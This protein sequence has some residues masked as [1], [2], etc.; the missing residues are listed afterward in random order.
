M[1]EMSQRERNRLDKQSRILNAAIKVFAE[2]G[3][4]NASMDDIAAC[5]GLTKPTLYKYFPSKDALFK[6]MMAAPKDVM[7][8]ALDA[9]PGAHLADQ[10]FQFAWAYADTVMHPNFLSLA[11]LIIGEAQRFP[12]IGRDYQK[13]GPDKVLA[14]LIA[15]MLAQ[16]DIGSLTFDDA[17]L[18][19]Q[20]FWGLI[21]SAPRNRALHIPDT[22][23]S[24]TALARYIHNGIRVFL[25]AYSTHPERDLIHLAGV[26]LRNGG[27]A[28]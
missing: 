10:L 16:R 11:R 19:A 15:F 1:K 22:D 25:R 9:K 12:D 18:A 20:D 6:A 3:Y 17:E 26:I 21:L 2:V 27:K 5:A 23:L 24:E 14:G 28:S 8:L 7:I 4:S 13:S